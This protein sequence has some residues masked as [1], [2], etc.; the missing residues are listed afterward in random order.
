MVVT[1]TLDARKP[2]ADFPIF[3][4][5][6]HEKA[7]ERRAG[8]ARNSGLYGAGGQAMISASTPG[9]VASQAPRQARIWSSAC[10]S[11]VYPD[12]QKC[13]FAGKPTRGFEPRTPSLRVMM[14]T[15]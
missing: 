6:M 14:A 4:Q 5:R 1:P 8:G 2:G 10:G 9:C 12:T 7:L 3:E 15:P 11:V 13:R